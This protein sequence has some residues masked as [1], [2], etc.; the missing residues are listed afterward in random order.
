MKK[1]IQLEEKVIQ[2]KGKEKNSRISKNN[3]AIFY[4]LYEKVYKEDNLKS[5][6]KFL[7]VLNKELYVLKY[8][9]EIGEQ[10]IYSVCDDEHIKLK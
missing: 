6:N 1:C 4:L 7:T 8:P 2:L 5:K 10:Y 9:H 3:K